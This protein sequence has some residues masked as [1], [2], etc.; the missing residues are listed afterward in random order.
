[1]EVAASGQLWA[2]TGSKAVDDETAAAFEGFDHRVTSLTMIA[3]VISVS[4]ARLRA[5]VPVNAVVLRLLR[6]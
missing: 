6:L 2:A 4:T 1:M 3:V 5:V